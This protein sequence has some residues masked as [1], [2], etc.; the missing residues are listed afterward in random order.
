MLSYI[1]RDLFGG[2]IIT[3]T[4]PNLVDASNI[5]Q[6]PDNQEVFLYPNSSISIIVE[7]LQRVEP[8]ESHDAIKFHFDSLA[9]D[10]DAVSST[11]Q[12][13]SVIPND[14]GDSTPSA[15]V[16][17]G[18][19]QVPKFNRQDPDELHVFMALYRVADKD[20]DL[21]VTFNVPTKTGDG[22]AVSPQDLT[23][24]QEH[25]NTFATNLQIVDY[26]LFA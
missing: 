20:I 23:V 24:A 2:A 21:V 6:V 15:I 12:T 22:G 5:R 19:Q 7:I 25:F 9:H 26:G 11:V 18:T 13:V 14:R 8:S 1:K 16:L 4:I 17:S 3:Q 10:N